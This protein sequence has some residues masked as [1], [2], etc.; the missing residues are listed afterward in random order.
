MNCFLTNVSNAHVSLLS[1]MPDNNIFKQP[2]VNEKF[3]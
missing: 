2:I 1:N 3:L